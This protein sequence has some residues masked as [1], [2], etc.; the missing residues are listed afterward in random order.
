VQPVELKPEPEPVSP[1]AAARAASTRRVVLIALLVLALFAAGLGFVWQRTGLWNPTWGA[2]ERV[3]VCPSTPLRPA[4]PQETKVNVYNATDRI[5]KAT[6]TAEALKS[7]GFRIG[8]VT[9]AELPDDVR[10]G[11]GVILAGPDALDRALALQRQVP[12][13]QIKL[14]PERTD[15]A[16][17]LVLG[18][19]FRG[20]VRADRVNMAP[21]V[22]RCEAALFGG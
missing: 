18:E 7:R 9:N 16:V 13:A 8:S 1:V 22:P 20:L 2:P 15:G 12:R 11:S 17:D 19:D 10:Q 6:A 5:G 21:G 14:Q 4:N 3:A